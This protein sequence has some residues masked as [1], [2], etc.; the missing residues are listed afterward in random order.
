MKSINT[1]NIGFLVFYL[2]KSTTLCR[3][4]SEKIS[5]SSHR[6]CLTNRIEISWCEGYRYNDFVVEKKSIN[7]GQ[8]LQRPHWMNVWDGD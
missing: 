3:I 6:I 8:W 5:I 2:M 1:D 7:G 4:S